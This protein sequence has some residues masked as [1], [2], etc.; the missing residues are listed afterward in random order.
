MNSVL[1][2]HG[3]LGSSQQLNPLKTILVDRGAK[4][5]GLNLSGHGGTPFNNDFGIE[6]FASEVQRLIQN[7]KF[8]P[9]LL[10]GYSMGGYVALWLTLQMPQLISGIITLGTKFD[11]SPESAE[12]EIR[13]MNPEKIEIKIPAL[14]RILEHRHQPNDWKLLMGKTAIMMKQ[15]GEQPLLTEENLK[16]I[17]SKVHVVLGDQ[18]DMADLAYSKEVASW[19][20]NGKFTLLKDAPHPIEK[21]D[22]NIMADLIL[23]A[24]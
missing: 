5:Y 9:V 20:P 2:L 23:Q 13:K 17:Q 11:W 15:L 1:L 12:R 22:P 21:T 19:I 4:V 7:Q 18:D 3:A 10:F 24:I 14:A 6:Q 16:K 8:N